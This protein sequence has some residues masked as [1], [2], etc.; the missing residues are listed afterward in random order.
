MD[1]LITDRLRD[2][3]TRLNLTRASEVL[4]AIAQQAHIYPSWTNCWRR[5][6]RSRR[7]AGSRPP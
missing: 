3:L 5:K 4:E 1:Q 6:W 7:S 2:N